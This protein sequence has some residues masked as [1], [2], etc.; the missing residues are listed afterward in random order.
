MSIA[1]ISESEKRH[2]SPYGNTYRSEPLHY[3]QS[4]LSLRPG[5]LTGIRHR[6]RVNKVLGIPIA[7]E[8]SLRGTASMHSL[9][10]IHYWRV[11]P[12]HAPPNR[13]HQNSRKQSSDG[14]AKTHI[15]L[16]ARVND[17]APLD[18]RFQLMRH[19][20]ARCT[21]IVMTANLI[22]HSLRWRSRQ[23]SA[24]TSQS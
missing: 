24:K 20:G 3:L 21:L 15:V 12:A 18:S 8:P 23:Y 11:R 9:G 16:T 2:D 17:A 6:V 7:D 13:K 4:G 5:P 22:F 1:P 14:N 10:W 19:R